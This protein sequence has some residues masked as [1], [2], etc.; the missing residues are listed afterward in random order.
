[1]WASF[2]GDYE[3]VEALLEVGAGDD[4]RAQYGLMGDAYGV[5]ELADDSV[6]L[7]PAEADRANKKAAEA[8]QESKIV[9]S[10]MHWAVYKVSAMCPIV[11]S[12]AQLLSSLLLP[13]H[14]LDLTCSRRRICFS[15]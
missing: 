15:F 14:P 13:L 8:K 6:Q 9:I 7:T 2:I 11:I 12:I 10:P 3:S 5:D 4:Y 1:M